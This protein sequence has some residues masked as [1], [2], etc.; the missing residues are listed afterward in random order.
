MTLVTQSKFRVSLTVEGNSLGVWD[1]STGG[2]ASSN[3]TVYN[4]GGGAPQV[5]LS[6]TKTT[7]VVT[8]TRAYDLQRDHGA[9]LAAMLAAEGGG[10]CTVKQVPLDAN[11]NA[12]GSPNVWT[13]ILTNVMIPPTDSNSSSAAIISIDVTPHGSPIAG[14]N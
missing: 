6:G 12:W 8:L 1:T 7:G 3:T 10:E 9:A 14:G 4:P 13:G 11:G 5:A 2:E